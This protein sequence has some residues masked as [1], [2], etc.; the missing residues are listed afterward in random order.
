MR[1]ASTGSSF[2]AA[3]ST[4]L[5]VFMMTTSNVDAFSLSMINCALS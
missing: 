3:S 4:R 2:F 1:S 5:S